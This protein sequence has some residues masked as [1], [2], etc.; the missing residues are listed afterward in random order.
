MPVIHE[1]AD[2]KSDVSTYFT[3]RALLS[4]L[5]QKILDRSTGE[6]LFNPN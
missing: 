1:A 6:D 4:I 3:T 5:K 2:F